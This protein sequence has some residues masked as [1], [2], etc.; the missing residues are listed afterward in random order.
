VNASQPGGTYSCP[1]RQR[2]AS[3]PEFDVS[4]ECS[5]GDGF[6]D[7]SPFD[8]EDAVESRIWGQ[9]TI[10]ALCGYRTIHIRVDTLNMRML[11]P[12]FTTLEARAYLSCGGE[13]AGHRVALVYHFVR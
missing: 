8:G 4:Y 10:A 5:R 9:K 1:S 12:P 6:V 7:V 13:G 11:S 3:G 2:C